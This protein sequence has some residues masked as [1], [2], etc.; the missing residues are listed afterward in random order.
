MKTARWLYWRLV[1]LAGTL[2]ALLVA[3][4]AGDPYGTGG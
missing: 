3:A 4:G 1:T 2:A